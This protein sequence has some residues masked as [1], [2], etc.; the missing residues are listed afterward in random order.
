MTD[1][2]ERFRKVDQLDD[3]DQWP[4][5]TSR[6]Q[7][8]ATRPVPSVAAPHPAKRIRVGIAAAL[9]FLVPA[10]FAWNALR[11]S[12]PITSAPSESVSPSLTAPSPGTVLVD[13]DLG[14][15]SSRMLAAIDGVAW[16]STTE[17]FARLEAG[18][19]AVPLP[20]RQPPSTLIA[21][22]SGGVWFGGF[23]PGT[24]PYVARISGSEGSPD[25]VIPLPPDT[26]VSHLAASKTA[27]WALVQPTDGLTPGVL[28]RI[29]PNNGTVLDRVTLSELT[30]ADP[31]N[32]VTVWDMSADESSVYLAVADMDHSL[33]MATNHRIVRIDVADGAV[34]AT[35]KGDFAI[36]CVV[37]SGTVWTGGA[38]PIRLDSD[39]SNPQ[40]L[41]LPLHTYPFGYGSGQVWFIDQSSK[42]I[43]RL[44][45]VNATDDQ[46]A[47]DVSIPELTGWGSVEATYDGAGHVWLFYENGRVQE[48]AV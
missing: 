13:V 37:A 27:L 21:S 7:A 34:T 16:A 19:P 40:K 17:T 9:V 20:M 29:D 25:I 3:P 32:G 5:I 43:I 4:E 44:V 2:K 1:L 30:A 11:R 22:P 46:I 18:T 41:A 42:K 35:Y 24:G 28:Y 39:L 45:A 23:E 10:A 12:S 8:G 36:Y 33:D 6:A 31:S 47:T 15:G 48:I 14:G 26:S 38:E